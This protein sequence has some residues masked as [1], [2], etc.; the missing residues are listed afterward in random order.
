MF[1]SDKQQ[2]LTKSYEAC[3]QIKKHQYKNFTKKGFEPIKLRDGPSEQTKMLIFATKL[4][5]GLEP[6]FFDYKT[7]T[8]P[9]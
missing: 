6:L 2:N 1:I 7:N 3:K 9:N 8:L 5:N 4:Y